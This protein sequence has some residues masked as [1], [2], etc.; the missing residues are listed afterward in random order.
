M[1]S[2]TSFP[3]AEVASPDAPSPGQEVAITLTMTAPPQA[4]RIYRSRWELRA[5]D[6]EAFGHL[7]AEI[8]TVPGSTVGSGAHHAD[9]T[10][11]AD[12]TVPD[13]TRFAE[14]ETFRKQWRVRNTGARKWGDGFRLV[15]VEGNLPMGRGVASHMV[16]QTSKGE[17]VILTVPMVAPLAQNGQPTT[18]QSLWRLQ[19]DRGNFF[20]SA[21]WARI[22]SLPAAGNSA[23]GRFGDPAG[24]YSQLDPRWQAEQLGHGQQTIGA[25]GCL[26]V[27]QAMMLTACGL[28]ITPSQLNQRLRVLGS[29]GFQGSNVQ[30][31]APT[32]LLGSLEQGRNFRSWA[33]PDIP[34]TEWDEGID[35]IARIDQA[36]AAGH[37]VFAQVDREPNN[38]FYHSNTEQHW[39]ILVT[40]T[41]DGD[42]Y[43]MLDP[44]TSPTQLRS[45]PVSLMLKYGNPAPSRPHTENLRNAIKS[46]LIY[47]CN[48]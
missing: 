25:W 28:P 20:G 35:P 22:I 42:D 17:E 12:H 7:Y 46:A 1:V 19:D 36:L 40:R 41:P 29:S 32:L 26:L 4:G 2:R 44:M 43:L 21:L 38:A 39:V 11:V 48:G 31:V 34:W 16:P 18:Y 45:Q 3:L 6:G 9:M 13:D 47:R 24:W 5:P 37:I 27:C 30:F 15:F 10:F 8:T 33:S 14:G 23:L